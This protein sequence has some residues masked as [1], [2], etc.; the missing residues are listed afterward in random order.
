MRLADGKDSATIYD[1]ITV[2]YYASEVESL[3]SDHLD[4]FK[5]LVRNEVSRGR[6]FSRMARNY[7]ESEQFFSELE[8]RGILVEQE[9]L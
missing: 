5:S 8:K 9:I 3:T 1:F 2:P 4:W 7:F 6:E